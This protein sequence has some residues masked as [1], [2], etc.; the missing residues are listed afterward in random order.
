MV[1]EGE[2]VFE[3]QYHPNAEI[4]IFGKEDPFKKANEADDV[5]ED[6]I[7]DQTEIDMPTNK[8][9]I[10]VNE[11]D[12]MEQLNSNNTRQTINVVTKGKVF[13]N[14]IDEEVGIN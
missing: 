11:E 9:F 13:K 1:H 14:A 3:K 4:D 5:D 8:K 12:S 10:G 6:D 7:E 2:E